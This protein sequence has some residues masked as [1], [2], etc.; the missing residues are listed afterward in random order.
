M[1]AIHHN[2]DAQMNW[3][4]NDD[5][6]KYLRV[7]ETYDFVREIHSWHTKIIIDGNKFNSVCFKIE[8]EMGT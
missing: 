4:G 7:G 1:K 6:R 5:T 2:S 3:G 8:K